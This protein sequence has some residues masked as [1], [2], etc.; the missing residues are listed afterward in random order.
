MKLI[1]YEEGQSTITYRRAKLPRGKA[2]VVFTVFHLIMNLFL[3]IMVLLIGII[4]LQKCYSK[5]FTMKVF[6]LEIFAVYG[7]LYSMEALL[8]Y[9]QGVW[10]TEELLG[11]SRN[12]P[13]GKHC[14]CLMAS[15]IFYSCTQWFI[16]FKTHVIMWS[17]SWTVLESKNSR[18][19]CSHCKLSRSQC[20]IEYVSI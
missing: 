12:L 14:N 8:L 7:M 13:I 16:M 20:N 11:Y 18:V 1:L 5:S 17:G 2:F 15:F 9:W 3:W 6:S 19:C 4:S 10:S